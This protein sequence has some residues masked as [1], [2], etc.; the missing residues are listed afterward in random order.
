MKRRGC[1][2]V[3]GFALLAM[4]PLMAYADDATPAPKNANAPV[5]N[6]QSMH[7]DVYAG[8]VHAVKA[9][10]VLDY[11]ESGRYSMVF[12]A[13]TRGLLGSLAP[14]SG[15][16]ESSGWV[17]NGRKL[18]PQ[19]HESI[20][21]WRDEREVKTY[22]YDKDKGFQNI[23]TT[24]VGKKPKIETPEAELTQGTT[25]ALT[26]TMMVMEH[27]SDGGKCEGESEIYDGKRRYK[28]IYRHQ[29]FVMLE[30]TRYNAYSGP[31]AECTVE[32][33][34]VA[35]HWHK[36][37][38]GWLSIQEQGRERGTMPTV[39]FA[40]ITPNAVVVPVRV[41]VKTAYGTLFMH[42]TKYESGDTILTPL[43]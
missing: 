40:Q 36:K 25:D 24:Y 29:Q 20:A 11:S 18:V 15:T 8:G 2:A 34:P 4:M 35:G 10:M 37:P 42:M 32:V 41:R 43:D 3:S 16:F 9:D 23:T 21:V 30:K 39:W 26:A 17:L 38:R 28:L 13:E 12:G 1:I 33:Q 14:W 7:Y 31:A 22:K 5:F 6:F 19:L 27:V